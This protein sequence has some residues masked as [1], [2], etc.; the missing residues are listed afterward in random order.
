[1]ICNSRNICFRRCS[2]KWRY[3]TSSEGLQEDSGPC[4]L[5]SYGIIELQ[6]YLCSVRA[7]TQSQASPKATS[8]P[9]T[10]HKWRH[11]SKLTPSK[12]NTDGCGPRPN[13]LRE[14]FSLHKSPISCWTS[15]VFYRKHSRSS[16]PVTSTWHTIF[17]PSNEVYLFRWSGPPGIQYIW[18]IEAERA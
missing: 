18:A 13:E 9:Q 16:L 15:I 6:F 17:N 1:M 8:R 4:A 3:V 5:H 11:F 12:S 10:I 7:L 14:Q 2:Y